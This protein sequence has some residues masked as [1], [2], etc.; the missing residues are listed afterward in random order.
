MSEKDNINGMSPDALEQDR[1]WDAFNERIKEDGTSDTNPFGLKSRPELQALIETSARRYEALSPVEKALADV[2]QQ[3]SWAHGEMMLG[4]DNGKGM[5]Q[6]QYDALPKDK[7]VILADEVER[8]AE[9][10]KRLREDFD[11]LEKTSRGR[12]EE[13]ELEIATIRSETI[14]E[15]AAIVFRGWQRAESHRMMWQKIIRSVIRGEEDYERAS[16]YANIG[17]H[18]ATDES[19]LKDVEAEILA[20]N[21]KGG[22]T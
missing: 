20:L 7:S 3:Q 13:L 4:M 18:Y 15:C 8:L 1:K 11:E 2:R 10:N 17:A 19:H 12:R 21:T 6:G 5:T 14:K 22:G 9:E 16:Y